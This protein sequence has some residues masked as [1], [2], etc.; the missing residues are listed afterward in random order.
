MIVA[1][2]LARALAIAVAVAV[3]VAVSH[4][5]HY[6][7]AHADGVQRDCRVQSADTSAAGFIE[8]EGR[9]GRNRLPTYLAYPTLP[10]LL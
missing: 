3:D 1:L 6:Y 4:H 8:F 2:G 10:K 5:H 7:D 9:Q